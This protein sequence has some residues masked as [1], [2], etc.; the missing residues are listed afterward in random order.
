MAS[1]SSRTTALRSRIRA[2]SLIAIGLAVL[3]AQ[4]GT[5]AQT[6]EPLPYSTGYLVAG[7]YVVGSVDITTSSGLSATGTIPMAGVP[8]PEQADI[9]AAF[10]YWETIAPSWAT[11]QQIADLVK[12][13]GQPIKSVRVKSKGQALTGSTAACF[14]AAGSLTMTMFRADVLRLLPRQLDKNGKPTGKLLVN[15]TDLTAAGLPLHTVAVPEAGNGNVIPQSAGAS[16]VVVFRDPSKP[17]KKIVV[18]DG[19][20]I[21]E[22]GK[23]TV[24][25]IRGVYQSDPSNKQA[26]ITH[27][28]GSGAKNPSE[29]LTVTGTT[30]KK[31]LDPFQGTSK[32]SDR[33]WAAITVDVSQQMPGTGISGPYGETVI[34]TISHTKKTPY[35][36]LSWTA[37]WFSTTVLDA[38]TPTEPA[39]RT[40]DGLPDRLE[41]PGGPLKD[42]NDVTLP[43]LYAM[44]A[45]SNQQDMFIEINA[46]YTSA[47]QTDAERTYGSAN[48]PYDSGLGID[49][50]PGTVD[51]T[52]AVESVV[53]PPHDHMPPSQVLELVGN[54]FNSQG[55]HVHFDVGNTAQYHALGPDYGANVG[56]GDGYLVPSGLARGGER[57]LEKKCNAA[58]PNCHFPDFAGT[59]GWGFSLQKHMRGIDLNPD[60]PRFD[61]NRFGLFH[62]ILYAHSRGKP[63]VLPCLDA[64]GTPTLYSTPTSTTC[65]IA[66][67][68]TFAYEPDDFHVPTSSSGAGDLPG[69]RVLVTLGRWEDFVGT[70]HV[71]AS[72]TLHELGHNLNLWHGG[73]PARLVND[74]TG[75]VKQVEANCKANYFSIMSYLFQVRGLLDAAFIPHIALSD[76]ENATL[77]EVF[78]KDMSLLA[79]EAG[80]LPYRSAWFAPLGNGTLVDFLALPAAT[81]LCNGRP[82]PAGL[83]M[84]RFDAQ[85]FTDTV[86][87]ATDGLAIGQSAAGQD[88][89][90][91]NLVNGLDP[92]TH[93][94][95]TGFDDWE[96]IRLDLV[97]SGHTMGGGVSNGGEDFGGEDFGGE[98]FGG[99]DF[100]GEDFGGE[101]FGGEDFGGEDFGGVDVD[102]ADFSSTDFG[103]ED[104]G[105]DGE[106][107]HELAKALGGGGGF[108]PNE[109]TVQVTGTNTTPQ[110]QGLAAAECHRIRLEWKAPTVGK[111]FK[112]LVYRIDV[113]D[114]GGQITAATPPP[115][116]AGETDASTTFFVEEELPNGRQ[117]IYFVKARFD[118]AAGKVS[119]AS[120]LAGPV[121][122]INNAPV[123]FAD[124]FTI[125]E[126][127]PTFVGNVLNANP[128]PI[129]VDI[130]SPK[131]PVLVAAP[132]A[133]AGAFTFSP[134]GSFSYTPAAN[135]NGSVQFTYRL[136][137][138]T[139]PG[140]PSEKMSA[141]SAIVTVT[142][143]VNPVNDAPAGTDGSA[144]TLEDIDYT[145]TAANF[146]FTDPFDALPIAAAGPNALA[147]VRITTLPATGT[148][149]NG[150][151][152]ISAGSE[153][154]AASIAAGNLRFSPVPNGNATP[155]TSFTFQVRDNGG[156][157]NGGVDLDPTPNTLT[158]HVTPVNDPPVG[159]ADS[160]TTDE[161]TS[162]VIA[163]PGVLVNDTAGPAAPLGSLDDETDQTL[164]VEGVPVTPPAFGDLSINANGSFTYTPYA[165]YNGPDSFRYMLWDNGSHNVGTDAHSSVVN[166]SITVN[167]VNDAPAG[168]DTLVSVLQGASKVFA[169][170]DFGFTDPFDNPPNN[171]SR[172]RITTV[173]AAGTLTNDTAVVTPGTFV[174]VADIDAGLF[175]FT[176]GA[177]ASGVPYTTFTFQV[178]DDGGTASGGINLDPSAD[179]MT[180]NVWVATTTAE[181][182][183]NA[184]GPAETPDIALAGNAVMMGLVRPDTTM[185]R[186]VHGVSALLPPLIASNTR[187]RVTFSYNLFTW[188]SYNTLTSLGTGYWDSFS[189]SLS[190]QPYAQLSLTDPL[191][192]GQSGG[193][194]LGFWYWGGNDFADSTLEC[195]PSTNPANTGCT[196]VPPAQVEVHIT[197]NG[198]GDTYLNVVLD[199][200][201][202][203]E[204]NHN[205]PSYGA[206]TILD[207]VPEP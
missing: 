123:A 100:G 130:D 83:T 174:T 30:S 134:D 128:A 13:R 46:L 200:R 149:T 160:Y 8:P 97:G 189:V 41:Q 170:S 74:G 80:S 42:P 110:C 47:A 118:S 163:A 51:D 138:A 178:E 78:L 27:I 172:V 171:L 35:D 158:I 69:S 145:F 179:T 197:G 26:K 120:N 94:V 105:G 117:F 201:T 207:V 7:D 146:G 198:G 72:T 109:L 140:P 25:N 50:T 20:Y 142:I 175:R 40:G 15:D 82:L 62:Y 112:Y 102:G 48:A 204:A 34:S 52:I 93:P 3:F 124:V 187:Y 77:D 126:D 17:L 103:G 131:F 173:P 119:G 114:T 99:E 70:L 155:Y 54:T 12:F 28:V 143:T 65:A 19:I 144:T 167:P 24:Q 152:V 177:G 135:F 104:F 136:E 91:D 45:R 39:A 43:D 161:D 206:I 203:P 81:K 68:P 192:T 90:L 33:S 5:E 181:C 63:R 194:L 115:V 156:T 73:A 151:G 182:V 147:A 59:I 88:T 64:F 53:A 31:V 186:C 185:N 58:E 139:W 108:P 159:G 44:G 18:Y 37:T 76:R 153:I 191:T 199:T 66:V 79:D 89:N 75:V 6:G 195:L 85:T 61:E 127:S 23:T 11:P 56:V 98:D 162:L 125:N 67:N 86:D 154:T 9:V 183:P 137:A 57:D 10:L 166:V 133:V 36:C 32:N 176:P 55:I 132:P 164:Y 22:Q 87:W 113:T 122:A 71:R 202:L 38:E 196:A 92:I 60:L 101:D 116:L 107:T 205:H 106:V 49:H 168:T 129:D 4:M 96:N 1:R 188:D 150:G 95:L 184:G 29:S 180:I 16:L 157:A 141:D 169:T 84:A 111:V 148:L 193:D 121:T 14:T 165:N 190:R 21:E 2:A